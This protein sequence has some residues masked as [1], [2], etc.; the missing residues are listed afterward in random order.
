MP[1]IA[2]RDAFSALGVEWIDR[3][4]NTSRK[5]VNIKCPWCELDDP[6][7]H[8]AVSLHGHGYYCWRDSRH[9]GTN[10]ERLLVKLGVKRSEAI[11]LLNDYNIDDISAPVVKV[12]RPLRVLRYHR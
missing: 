3:G 12:D 8:L 5:S 2:W 4:R 11:R 6:S 10:Y 7:Y 9:S 1:I